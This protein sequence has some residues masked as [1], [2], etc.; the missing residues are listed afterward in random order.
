MN[1]ILYATDDYRFNSN[2]DV[3]NQ[4]DFLL[5]KVLNSEYNQ[6]FWDNNEIVKRTEIE[7]QVVDDFSRI[8][9]FG[10]LDFD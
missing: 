7:Q 3:M 5:Q 2:G 9:Y 10:S 1:S 4:K 6:A 8:G